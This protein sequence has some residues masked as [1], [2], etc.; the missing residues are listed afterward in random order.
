MIIR[1][2]GLA[3]IPALSDLAR[4]TYADAFGA[5]MT[6]EDLATQLHET[7][8]AAAFRAAMAAD[9]IL[10]ASIADDLAGY[11]QIR[12]LTLPVTAAAHGCCCCGGLLLILVNRNSSSPSAPHCPSMLASSSLS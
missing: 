4:D 11:V 6:A 9:T 10:V 1:Q 5:S 7:R 8:S 3:D 12:D 2:A